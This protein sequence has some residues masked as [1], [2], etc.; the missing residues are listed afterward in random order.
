MEICWHVC[1]ALMHHGAE[2]F[3][4][5]P[6]VQHARNLRFSFP[7]RT[8][9][10]VGKVDGIFLQTPGRMEGESESARA[11]I[12]GCGRGQ[13]QCPGGSVMIS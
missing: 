6:H 5:I 9:K 2:A 11:A 1:P 12:P 8:L 7:N 10:F 13:A 4:Q 3:S